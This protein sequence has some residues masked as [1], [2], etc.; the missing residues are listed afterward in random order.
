MEKNDVF[1]RTVEPEDASLLFLWENTP[2][3][4][5]V[6]GRTT[7]YSLPEIQSYIANAK[8]VKVLGQLRFMICKSSNE[9]P[10][11]TIDLYD[12]NFTAKN[13][14]IGVLIVDKKERNNGF[15]SQAIEKCIAIGVTKYEIVNYFCVIHAS[16]HS[17]VK[18]FEK[19][20]FERIGVKK[21]WYIVDGKWE[22]EL[23]YQRIED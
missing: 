8:E 5:R 1:L 13:A 18:L 22:D 11:G 7:T 3:V 14:G 15:A 2:E 10:I 21:K 9:A 4:M 16:N 6:S 17:S 23:M 19:N 12:M 20:G